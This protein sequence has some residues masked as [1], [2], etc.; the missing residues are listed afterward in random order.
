ME[1]IEITEDFIP[2]GIIKYMILHKV[3]PNHQSFDN[4]IQYKYYI[5]NREGIIKIFNDVIDMFLEIG[6]PLT[7][8]DVK[9][10]F[11]LRLEI[12]NLNYSELVDDE[13]FRFC[14]DKNFFPKILSKFK[15]NRESIQYLLDHIDLNIVPDFVRKTFYEV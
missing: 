11:E 13:I 2:Y 12:N 5:K 3:I 6:I 1:I 7:K 15:P 9:S 10:C 4:I 8:D 14:V